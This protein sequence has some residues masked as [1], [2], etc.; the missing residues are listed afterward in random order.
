MDILLDD[1][2]AGRNVEYSRKRLEDAP[3]ELEDIYRTMLVAT[4]EDSAEDVQE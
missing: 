2:D 1:R 3:Q 4:T